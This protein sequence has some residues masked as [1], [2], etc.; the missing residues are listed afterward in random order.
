MR[1]CFWFGDDCPDIGGSGFGDSMHHDWIFDVLRDLRAYASANGMP[2]LA[3]KAEEALH[4]AEAE[5]AARQSGPP[6]GAVP[7][8]GLQH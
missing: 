5:L 3:A 4:I 6:S 7:P 2:A 1:D 8:A